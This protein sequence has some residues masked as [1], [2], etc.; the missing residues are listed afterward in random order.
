MKGRVPAELIISLLVAVMVTVLAGYVLAS[1]GFSAF[2]YIPGIRG[3]AS[4]PAHRNWIGVLS[5]DWGNVPPPRGDM[6]PV[7]GK[8]P[9]GK[10]CFG[11]FSVLKPLDDSS[12]E[13][14]SYCDRGITF[15]HIRVELPGK[16]MG[17]YDTLVL[18]KVKILSVRPAGV[19][20][21]GTKTEIVTLG[22]RQIEYQ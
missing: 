15:S 2:L 4:D 19:L 22:F 9:A 1:S 7:E 21:N 5:C 3:E 10:L 17:S 12:R 14:S 8:G 16:I 11:D 6:V 18:R 13:I 20:P